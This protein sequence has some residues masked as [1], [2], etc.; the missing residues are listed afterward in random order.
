MR[1]TKDK[2]RYGKDNPYDKMLHKIVVDKRL[3]NFGYRILTILVNSNA[4]KYTPSYSSLAKQFG[5]DR[6]VIR[7]T[8][9]HLRELGYIHTSGTPKN[10]VLHVHPIP[11]NDDEIHAFSKELSLSEWG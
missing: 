5:V 11:L 1:I 9:K 6:K 2:I 10:T 3:S 8:L 7:L 4:K